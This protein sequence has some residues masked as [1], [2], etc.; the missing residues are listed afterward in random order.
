MNEP[1]VIHHGRVS[2]YR[3]QLRYEISGHS[4]YETS[5]MLYMVLFRMRNVSLLPGKETVDSI[6]RTVL[7]KVLGRG[8]RHTAEHLNLTIT[9]TGALAPEGVSR[10][11]LS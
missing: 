9:S 2:R 1:M 8:P 6:L 11:A 4:G 3:S 10:P 5:E 7:M